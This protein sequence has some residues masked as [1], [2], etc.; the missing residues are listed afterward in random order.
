MQKRVTRLLTT[1][2][3]VGMAA[4]TMGCTE[5]NSTI[6]IR[7][8][9]VP[10][11]DD[12]CVVRADPSSLYTGYG[13]LDTGI[14]DGAYQATMLVGNQMIRRGDNDT[15]RTE[16]GRVQL[17]EAELE[18]F[19]YA[20]ALLNEYTMPVS[21]FADPGTGTEPGWGLSGATL[22]DA[23]SAGAAGGGTGQTVVAR[24]KLYG[25]SLG[26][27]E[28]ETAPWD[29]PVFVCS[30]C[31]S[32]IEPDTCEDDRLQVCNLGQDTSPDCRDTDPNHPCTP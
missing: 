14:G 6:F 1:G 15:M 17:Y 5:T 24:V 30:G 32:C 26:G 7:Q 18:V 31:L 11:P 27:E 21:G 28:V 4:A 13:F 22:V 16:T 20:G 12:Q 10:D 25:V 9:Q 2:L 19:D 29:F 3:L 23:G 8:V